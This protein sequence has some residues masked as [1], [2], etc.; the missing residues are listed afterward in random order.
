MK[1]QGASFVKVT[2]GVAIQLLVVF[3]LFLSVSV[4]ANPIDFGFIKSFIIAKIDSYNQTV[5]L[6]GHVALKN[7]KFENISESKALFTFDIGREELVVKDD[8]ISAA[9]VVDPCTNLASTNGIPTPSDSDGDGIND[10]CDIDDDNDGIIDYDEGC[11]FVSVG[12]IKVVFI[13]DTSGSIDNTEYAAMTTSINKVATQILTN[14]ATTEIAVVQYGGTAYVS[15]QTA[16]VSRPFSTEHPAWTSSKR[17][18]MGIQD[19]L[20]ASLFDVRPFWEAGGELDLTVPSRVSF[21]IFTDAHKN[22]GGGCCTLLSNSG[23]QTQNNALPGYGEYD[24]IKST[25]NVRFLVGHHDVTVSGGYEAASAIASYDN[26][27]NLLVSLGTFTL[28]QLQINALA[29]G[30]TFE[31]TPDFDVDQA[32][33]CNDLDSDNDGIYDIVES[34]DITIAALDTNNNG[35]IDRGDSAPFV[36]ANAN[37]L[38]DR[39]E[40]KY[41]TGKGIIPRETIATRPDYINLDSDGDACFDS[42]EAYLDKNTSSGDGGEFGNADAKTINDPEID[43]DGTVVAASYQ[44]PATTVSGQNTFQSAVV[45]SATTIPIDQSTCVG[46]DIL[47]KAKGVRTKLATN[48]ATTS[49]VLISFQ[50]YENDVLI[51]GKSGTVSSGTEVSL[52]LTEVTTDLNNNI[53]KVVFTNEGNI[54]G[55]ETAAKLLVSSV[56][57]EPC[58]YLAS[59]DGNPTES[60]ADGDGINNVCDLDDDN[61]G[62][63]DVNEGGC[64]KTHEVRHA[65]SFTQTGIASPND[66]LASPDGVTALMGHGDSFILEFDDIVEGGGNVKLDITRVNSTSNYRISSSVNKTSWSNTLVYNAAF[67]ASVNVLETVNYTVPTGGAKYIRFTRTTGGLLIDAVS[68]NFL[69]C[70]PLNTDTDNDSIPDYLDLDADGDGCPDALEG[71]G[72]FVIADLLVSTMDGGNSNVSTDAVQDNLTG[73]PVQSGAVDADGVPVVANGGQ[74]DVSAADSAVQSAECDSCNA[75]S[76]LFTDGDNDGIGDDCD[77]D[78]DNDGILDVDEGYCSV[79]PEVRHAIAY[80]QTGILNPEDLLGA[81]NDVSA[82]MTNGNSLIIELADIVKEGDPIDFRITRYNL[83]GDYTIETSTDNVTWTNPLNYNAASGATLKFLETVRYTVATGGAKFIR[84]TRVN[85]ALEIDAVSYDFLCTSLDTDGDGIPNY[86]DLDGDNDGCPDAVEGAANILISDL[87]TATSIRGAVDENGVPVLATGG[88]AVGGSL[89]NL[90]VS[91]AA[92]SDQLNVLIGSDITFTSV[93]TAVAV[94]NFS[95]DPDTTV[96]VTTGFSYQWYK[97]TDGGDNYTKIVGATAS[98][99]SMTNVS[100]AND[101]LYKVAITHANN[102]CPAEQTAT[103][104]ILPC[105]LTS[106]LSA[107]ASS[108]TTCSPANDGQITISNGGLFLNTEY[109]VTFKKDG[110]AVTTFLPNPTTDASGKIVLT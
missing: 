85:G 78:K 4:K 86:L 34:G 82:R 12:P 16:I 26:N 43:E 53:Y 61:D 77:L 9:V 46:S 21:I 70:T 32:A 17:V 29:H 64:G 92:I 106:T 33:N 69:I 18:P 31:D 103:L 93:L 58:T 89:S 5:K 38:D 73:S 56:I 91:V 55:A 22:Y 24:F 84:F 57:C 30:A 15:Q 79:V 90:V 7:V 51:A 75:A 48:P 88:Q 52:L 42:D 8:F 37:G 14:D 39:I 102:S 41:G 96:P 23:S 97:S 110:E 36:D 50:W 54:C 105:E 27:G 45:V 63:L 40:A 13:L 62:I 25:Y 107:V 98:T 10:V 81:P 3:L 94:T 99:F 1:F 83:T 47:F 95:T 35:K 108:P 76:S 20:P 19:H 66:A 11:G 49:N 109:V 6:K 87:E 68:Y 74:E 80:V 60:D 104:S 100:T 44:V 101:G 59:T 65:T 2:K 72:V 67:G 71:G 28:S